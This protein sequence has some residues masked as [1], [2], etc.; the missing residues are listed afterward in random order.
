M[1]R[2][3][4]MEAKRLKSLKAQV[5]R[6]KKVIKD[7]LGEGIWGLKSENQNFTHEEIVFL[8]ARVFYPLGFDFVK[9]VRTEYPDCICYKDGQ[10]VGIEFEPVLSAFRNH[11]NKDDLSLCQYIVCW[12]DDLKIYDSIFEELKKH[13]IE[14]VELKRIYEEGK[15]TNRSKKCIIT[16]TDIDR[17][18]EN[19]LEI[20]NTFIQSGRD[21][22]SQEEI[23][24]AIGKRGRGLGGAL[25]G[26]TE[27]A[28]KKNDW[29]IRMRPRKIVDKKR[30]TEWELNPKHI[31][32]ITNT[33][34]KYNF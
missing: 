24:N 14:V 25:K 33:L 22:I 28:K 20:L 34:K 15:I 23:G 1:W 16:Q 19:K 5:S 11:I 9:K 13:N 10:E 2:V 6:S 7:R 27:L 30:V 29:I 17:F 31:Y 4:D 12:K 32:K 21:I 18:S 3:V 26:F 8:F